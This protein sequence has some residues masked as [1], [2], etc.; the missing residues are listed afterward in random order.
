M[1]A[2][3]G[4]VLILLAVC[5]FSPGFF[6]VRRFRWNPMEKSG[7]AIGVSLIVLYLVAT[8]LHWLAPA[9]WRIPCLAVSGLCLVLAIAMA[10]D[11]HRLAVSP[12]VRR[13]LFGF[14]FLLGWMLSIQATIRIYS[15]GGWAGDWL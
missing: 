12:A 10:R 14:L 6:I 7:A 15:G 11:I 2:T 8:V 1:A 9:D 3:L 13:P 5:S 4:L